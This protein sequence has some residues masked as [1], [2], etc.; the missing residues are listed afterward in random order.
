M[1]NSCSH[2][3]PFTSHLSLL[4]SHLKN[5]SSHRLTR[6]SYPPASPDLCYYLRLL[7]SRCYAVCDS[8]FSASGR[9]VLSSLS[10]RAFERWRHSAGVQ[11]LLDERIPSVSW[12]T[13]TCFLL[14]GTGA[15]SGTI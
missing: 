6:R 3:S 9:C 8:V 7:H 1:T 14:R 10:I 5:G 12:P 11:L 2:L 13:F 15:S 4:T